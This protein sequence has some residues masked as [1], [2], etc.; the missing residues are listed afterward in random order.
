MLERLNVQPHIRWQIK[1]H[2]RSSRWHPLLPPGFPHEDDGG[3]ALNCILASCLMLEIPEDLVRA[4]ETHFAE[5]EG[6]EYAAV[7]ARIPGM[8]ALAHDISLGNYL[9]HEDTPGHDVGHCTPSRVAAGHDGRLLASVGSYDQQWWPLALPENV[10]TPELP[11]FLWTLGDR[12]FKISTTLELDTSTELLPD[13]LKAAGRAARDDLSAGGHS[14]R[15]RAATGVIFDTFHV[16]LQ[17]LISEEVDDSRRALR[18]WGVSASLCADGAWV[19]P[20]CALK[21]FTLKEDLLRHF[22]RTHYREVNGTPSTKQ[23][24]IIQV[25]WLQCERKLARSQLF[26]ERGAQTGERRYLHTSAQCMLDQLRRS[27]SWATS[28]VSLAPRTIHKFVA[29]FDEHIKLFL[30]NLDTRFILRQDAH[31]F[32]TLGAH[33]VCSDRFLTTV[34]ASY[35]HPDTHGAQLRV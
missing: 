29:H 10:P 28:L 5:L 12:F 34:Y 35:L 30:D 33:C 21:S 14:I 11:S 7:S 23:Q 15:T 2:A 24:G 13:S 1:P 25:L 9:M 3:A 16:S 22:D 19:C 27:P 20:A 32:H 17:E 31:R 18:A 4:T 6:L 26:G 8:M